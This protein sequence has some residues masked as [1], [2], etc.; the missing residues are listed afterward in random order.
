MPRARRHAHGIDYQFCPKC[1]GPLSL[2][3]I[4]KIEPRR[5]VCMDCHFVF[6]LDP[7]VAATTVVEHKGGL[8]MVKRTV[9]PGYGL[10]VIPGGFVDRG[11]TPE[12]AAVRETKE[13]A[14]ID[15]RLTGLIGIYSYPGPSVVVISYAAEWIGGKLHPTDESSD[16]RAFPPAKIPW[17][18][19]AFRST[20]DALKHYLA[21]RE[22]RPTRS[23]HPR[24]SFSPGPAALFPSKQLP[25]R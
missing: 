25:R 23:S 10:W 3:R 15:V 14:N 21:V 5:L 20:V 9:E 24:P 1:G 17:K 12:D 8:V 18:Q 13:E 22:G 7:K 11:E 2:L 19:I 16:A 6:Y 4:K